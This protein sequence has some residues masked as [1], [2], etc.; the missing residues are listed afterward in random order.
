M[1][2]LR[3]ESTENSKID[4]RFIEYIDLEVTNLGHE[5]FE[6]LIL[7][8][9][10]QGPTFRGLHFVGP[11]KVVFIP[12]IVTAYTPFDFSIVTNINTYAYT[13]MTMR[14]WNYGRNVAI[15]TQED[16]VRNN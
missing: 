2:I 14:A 13:G 1:S 9:G 7:V 10:P 8:Y 15:F 3:L 11:G 16:A 5:G 12:Q 4:S 6:F